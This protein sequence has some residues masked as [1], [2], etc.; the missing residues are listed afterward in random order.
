MD[1]LSREPLHRAVTRLSRQELLTRLCAVQAL[2]AAR[3]L[4]FLA[5]HDKPKIIE[6]ALMPWI[7]TP[8]QVRFFHG[9]TRLMVE[10]LTRLPVLYARHKA[11]QRILPLTPAQASWIHLASRRHSRPLALLGRLDSTAT[12][13][14]AA[15]RDT[16][17]MLEPNTVGVGGV[18]YAPAAASVVLDVLGDVFERVFP[19]RRVVPMPDPREL[20]F[21]EMVSVSRRLGRRLRGIALI[22][23]TDF[24][25][26]TDEFGSLASYF[27]DRGLC[28]VVVDPRALRVSNGNL[29]ANGR[30][31]D[32]LYR[33]CELNEFL[34]MEAGGKRLT[35]VRQAVA[36]GRLISGL[37]WEFDQKSCWEMFTDEAYARYFTPAQRRLFRHH[38]PWTRLVRE[39]AVSDPSGRRVGL[40]TYIRRRKD[41]LVLK[42]NTLY[43]GQ[44]VVVGDT[45][46]QSVWEQTLSKA[47]RGRTHY[48]VQERARIGTERFP[49]LKGGRIHEVERRVV[50]GFFVNSTGVGLIGRFSSDPVVN[51]SRGGG[52][53]SALMVQ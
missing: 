4:R 27:A 14:H 12:F 44:G 33:D 51:V 24:T 13:S 16:F 22:E 26:G 17:Q 6:L 45:V 53:L 30:S 50:S 47:L 40:T 19:G 15:W 1:Y 36:Q 32:V 37:L 49:R 34:D 48:V 42:P 41:H 2:S 39:A 38:L 35:A 3:G 11:V 46:S 43:G 9:V 23:N 31:V 52:L 10:A 25:T 29:T 7:L 8:A 21:E 18:H 20:L 28:A 5:G